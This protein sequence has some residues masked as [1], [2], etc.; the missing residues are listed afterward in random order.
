MRQ[1]GRV[2]RARLA[3]ER[4]RRLSRNGEP[5]YHYSGVSSFAQYAVTVPG[6]LVKVDP[7]VPLDVAAMFGC[8]VVTGRDVFNAAKV[9]PGQNV[10]VFGLG[11]V[12][13]NSV[14]AAKISGASESSASTLTKPSFR[15][16]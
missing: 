5:V 13:L 7:S 16:R 6:T 8:A 9:R 2:T 14:M 15:W 4:T 3:A 10:A 12:G 11:G 1:R